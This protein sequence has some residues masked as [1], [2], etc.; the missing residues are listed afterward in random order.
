MLMHVT[1]F[2]MFSSDSA[3]AAHTRK[4]GARQNN[5]SHQ[6]SKSS[7]ER[8]RERAVHLGVLSGL[9][10]K[11]KEGSKC[12][13]QAMPSNKEFVTWMFLHEFH[14]L[15][16]DAFVFGL[17]TTILSFLSTGCLVKQVTC[18]F[19]MVRSIILHT[20]RHGLCVSLATLTV[21]TT[22]DTNSLGLALDTLLMEWIGDPIHHDLNILNKV[23]VGDTSTETNRHSLSLT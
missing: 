16:D 13:T 14:H 15:R 23:L 12:P 1:G 10:F 11:G 21:K 22:M 8:E 19:F 7:R 9:T 4:K 20:R 17:E 6:N 18:F 5:V 3:A 2:G